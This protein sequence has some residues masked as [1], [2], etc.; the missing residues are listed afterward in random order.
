MGKSDADKLN[1]WTK[2]EYDCFISGIDRESKYYVIFEILFWTGCRE[3][4]DHVIIRLKLD[5]PSKYAGLS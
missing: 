4:D 2:D 3:G 5:K 1:F